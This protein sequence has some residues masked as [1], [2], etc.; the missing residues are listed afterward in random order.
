MLCPANDSVPALPHYVS[1]VSAHLKA[2]EVSFLAAKGAFATPPVALRD[3]LLQSYVDVAHPHV[4]V[5]DMVEVVN[6]LD[7]REMGTTNRISFL[8][9]Q[10]IMFVGAA[11]VNMEHLRAAG[12]R[13]RRDACDTLFQRAKL[14]YEFDYETEEYRDSILQSLILISYWYQPCDG[15]KDGLHWLNI[16]ISLSYTLCVHRDMSRSSA[17]AISKQRLYKRTWWSLYVVDQVIGLGLCQP[18]RIK[19]DD[20]DI[21]MPTLADFEDSELPSGHSCLPDRDTLLR[22]TPKQR[23]VAMV[24]IEKVRLSVCIGRMLSKRCAVRQDAQCHYSLRG[25][26][27]T[28]GLTH[29]DREG[30]DLRECRREL[31]LWKANLPEEVEHVYMPHQEN[32]VDCGALAFTQCSMYMMYFTALA[33][34]GQ[35]PDSGHAAPNMRNGECLATAEAEATTTLANCLSNTGFLVSHPAAYSVFLLPGVLAYIQ[36]TDIPDSSLRK[37]SY[38]RPDLF[39]HSLK[40]SDDI[41]S[42]DESYADSMHVEEQTMKMARNSTP[43]QP[44][45]ITEKAHTLERDLALEHTPVS[46]EGDLCSAITDDST[47]FSMLQDWP[48]PDHTGIEGGMDYDVDIDGSTSNW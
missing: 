24:F 27:A 31:E 23:R 33:F 29:G 1:P 14:L 43:P 25:G 3:R 16:A 28:S 39:E 5:V 8:L 34:F 2:N 38:N 19:L 4:P 12:Y 45:K 36:S 22:D 13:S 11:S 32:T 42:T 35:R 44:S 20:F 6:I 48:G 41:E 7:G 17:V 47:A 9:F 40:H 26:F 18:A 21:P 46:S 37:A 15:L 10:T 30:E